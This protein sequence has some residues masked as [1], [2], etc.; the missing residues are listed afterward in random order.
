MFQNAQEKPLR[1]ILGLMR[2]MSAP[3][4]KSVQWVPIKSDTGPPKPL[5]TGAESGKDAVAQVEQV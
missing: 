2:G 1:Q 3:T 4:S 5:L